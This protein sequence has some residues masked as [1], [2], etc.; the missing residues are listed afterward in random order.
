MNGGQAGAW[1]DKFTAV[2]FDVA[3]TLAFEHSHCLQQKTID[4]DAAKVLRALHDGGKRIVLCSNTL[5]CET[6]WPALEQAGVCD[7][8]T[9]ALLSHAVG[10]R[11]PDP[12]MYKLALS[13]A[14]CLPHEALFVGD[15]PRE[16]VAGPVWCGMAA[17]LVWDPHAGGTPPSIP[18]GARVI[19]HVRDLLTLS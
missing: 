5:P 18:A 12:L 4:P 10:V 15:N 19:A 8:V 2:I 7:T 9:A 16:D 13:A 11:K 14:G 1:V 3:G 17:C 6:R